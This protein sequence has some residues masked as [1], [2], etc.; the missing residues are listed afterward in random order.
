MDVILLSDGSASVDAFSHGGNNSHAIAQNAW[1]QHLAGVLLDHAEPNHVQVFNRRSDV[2]WTAASTLRHLRLVLL[3]HE[4][5]GLIPEFRRF[6]EPVVI[7]Q[8][9]EGNLL[10]VVGLAEE[11]AVFDE[12]FSNTVHRYVIRVG[13]T[14][15]DAGPSDDVL[16]GRNGIVFYV[17]DWSGLSVDGAGRNPGGELAQKVMAISILSTCGPTRRQ[18]SPCTAYQNVVCVARTTSMTST[19]TTTLTTTAT[20]TETTIATTSEPTQRP[21]SPSPTIPP[22]L[23]PT[24]HPTPAP[25]PFPTSEPT[26]APTPAP[27]PA[28]T[29]APTL[30]PT[31]VPT[32]VPTSTLPTPSPTPACPQNCGDGA[33]NLD[34]RCLGCSA[35]RLL[36]HGRCLQSISCRRRRVQSGSLAGATCRCGIGHC[37]FCIQNHVGEVCRRC[38]DGAYLLDGTC[39]QSCPANMASSGINLF[40]RLCLA[41]FTCRGGRILESSVSYGCKCP[42]E[43]NTPGGSCHV[44]EHRAGE[45]GD[46]CTRCSGGRYLWENRCRADCTGISG[47]IEY[48]PSA[49]GRQCRAPFICVLGFDADRQPCKC[50]RDLRSRYCRVCR[51]GA[52]GSVCLDD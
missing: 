23:H 16:A 6:V 31:S 24:A 27:S 34:G 2:G 8:I 28:P 38:R 42:G 25:T 37:H 50:S 51:W 15:S 33:C 21:T 14:R 5:E 4:S 41:P 22:T 48:S 26:P 18:T 52:D 40:G 1:F 35:N 44:C 3:A 19:L 29:T 9:I 12:T 36:L 20:T 46:H 7:V 10:D 45:I 17:P 47:V 32:I 13:A 49:Y 39:V 11:S 43:G 30:T